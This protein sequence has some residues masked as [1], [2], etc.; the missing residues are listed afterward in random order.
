MDSCKAFH[1]L[2]KKGTITNAAKWDEPLAQ[3][4]LLDVM[5]IISKF[6]DQSIALKFLADKKILLGLNTNEVITIRKLKKLANAAKENFTE[7][8]PQANSRWQEMHTAI[9]AYLDKLGE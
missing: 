5:N 6:T 1:E 4:N 7:L 2:L 8:L 9:N 3:K